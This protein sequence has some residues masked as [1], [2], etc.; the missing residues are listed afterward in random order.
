MSFADPWWLGLLA[1]AA[2]LVGGYVWRQRCRHRDVLRFTNLALL[3]RVA[4]GAPGWFRHLPIGMLLLARISTQRLR[5]S[6]SGEF[7]VEAAVVPPGDGG[8]RGQVGLA[9]DG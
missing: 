9:Q 2:A 7:E 5:P 8:V 3:E 4:P 6:C 1:V